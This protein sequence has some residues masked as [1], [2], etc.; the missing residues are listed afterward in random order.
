MQIPGIQGDTD[1]FCMKKEIGY[2]HTISTPCGFALRCAL[3]RNLILYG[4]VV[5]F[6]Y[7]LLLTPAIHFTDFT[8]KSVR[9]RGNGCQGVVSTL[10][11]RPKPFL[12]LFLL[13][14][15]PFKRY[16]Q[17]T[18][19]EFFYLGIFFWNSIGI[20]IYPPFVD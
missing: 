10:A 18:N 6:H 9:A 8:L 12:A 19:F 15:L 17:K 3:N 14:L 11:F 2:L 7:P 5:A 16:R 13:Y 4:H 20:W 1:N